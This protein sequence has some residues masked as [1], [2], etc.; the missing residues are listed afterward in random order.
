MHFRKFLDPTCFSAEDF[1]DDHFNPI[2]KTLTIKGVSLG[3][4][5]AGGKS[6]ACFTV[7][8]DPRKMF[9]GNKEIK[10]IARSLREAETDKWTGA[11]IQITS[12]P[13]KAPDG[14]P[15]GTTGM[16]V[17]QAAYHKG[18]KNTPPGPEQPAAE[19]VNED[20]ED[21]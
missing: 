8:E 2:K 9:L 12:G 5:P 20:A 17:L 11:K 4:P 1:I 16:V 6:K 13:K 3:K 10:K 14:N 7:E 21:P 19:P 15:E 18:H